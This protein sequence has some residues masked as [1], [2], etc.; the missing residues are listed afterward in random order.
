MTTF[1]LGFAFKTIITTNNNNE[2]K[3]VTGIG[4]FFF[5]G[6]KTWKHLLKN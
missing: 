1:C 3:K 6:L 5:T 4:G 2:M